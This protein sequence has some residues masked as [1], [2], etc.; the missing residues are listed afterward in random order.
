[1]GI[2]SA[3]SR[4]WYHELGHGSAR[5]L[6]CWRH[7]SFP[8]MADRHQGALPVVTG[9][10]VAGVSRG[11]IMIVFAAADSLVLPKEPMLLLLGVDQ[12]LD[13][14]RTTMNVVGNCLASAV[15]AKW[16]GEFRTEK[17]S[18]SVQGVLAE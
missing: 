6:R 15:I 17:P 13:M 5:Y 16:E 14:G 11:S 10:G 1:V 9:K 18:P 2:Q 7:D 8:Y 12:F 4:S 3:I